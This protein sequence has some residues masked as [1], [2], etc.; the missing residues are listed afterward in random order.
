MLSNLEELYLSENNISEISGLDNLVRDYY[1]C[2][3]RR[4]EREGVWK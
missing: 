2:S 3:R 4:R 1:T